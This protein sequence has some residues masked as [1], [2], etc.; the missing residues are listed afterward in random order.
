MAT[1]N[2]VKIRHYIKNAQKL[3]KQIQNKNY[4]NL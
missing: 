4:E 1:F 3:Q 2:I